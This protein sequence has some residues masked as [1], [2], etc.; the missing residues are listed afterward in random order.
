MKALITG[1]DGFIGSHLADFLLD[2]GFDVYCTVRKNDQVKNLAHILDKIKVF[3]CDISKKSKIQDIIE[4][5]N[6]DHIYHMAAQS[7]VMPSWKDIEN[8]FKTNISGTLFLLDSIRELKTDPKVIIA[9]S[10]A[11]YGLTQKNELPIKEN[12]EF[13]PSSPYAVSK[14]A[15]DMLAYL[16]WQ[17]YKMKVFR[18][19]FFNIT[20]PRKTGDACSDFAKMVVEAEKGKKNINVGNLEGIRDITDVRDA[21]SAVWS[22]ITKGK[23]G[24]VYNVCS[25]IGYKMRDVLNLF[26]KKS[27]LKNPNIIINESK[28]RPFDD[29][30]FI[31]DN[32]KVKSLNWIPKIGIETTIVDMLDYWRK[33]I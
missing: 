30:V 27:L 28:I 25:S 11:E 31:G 23:E 2:K 7:F 15:T 32:T 6:P 22:I 24:D 12:K 33:N 5:V 10:S 29:P 13:R 1:G 16:Y 3:E 8:T 4:Y 18:V 9:C 20:G 19:R 21:I 26:I 17:T 14:V